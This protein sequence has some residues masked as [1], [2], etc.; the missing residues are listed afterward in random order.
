[1]T[2]GACA[3][4]EKEWMQTI[5]PSVKDLFC[6]RR[7]MDDVL[8]L[9]A[10]NASWDHEA[11]SADMQRST[12]YVP[13]LALTEGKPDTFLETRFSVEGSHIR[14]WLKNDNERDNNKV[15]QYQH[16][17]SHMPYIQKR[18][19]LTSTL[20]K[21]H[22]MAGDK[23]ALIR[24]AFAKIGEFRRLCYPLPMVK[25]ACTYMAATHGERTWLDIRDHVT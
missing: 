18:A 24:S 9:Y 14:H 13:P 25:A 23:H 10:A 8:L 3:W 2:I 15:W 16:F 5:A 6:A 4:M 12:C 19:L 11:F 22:Q 17:G 20:K 7:Y 1:M 21:V